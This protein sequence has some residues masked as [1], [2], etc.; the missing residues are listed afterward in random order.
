MKLLIILPLEPWFKGGVENVVKEYSR[1]LRKNHE[2]TLLCTG[3][4]MKKSMKKKIWMGIPVIIFKSYG[5]ILRISP[6]L[7]WYV[8]RIGKNF[9]LVVIHNYS[10]LLPAQVIWFKKEIPIPVVLTP[11]FHTQG[12][13][14]LLKVFRSIYDPF[15]K[16]IF[17]KR[18][19]AVQFVSRTEKAEFTRKFSVKVPYKVIYNGINVE[20]FT[21]IEKEQKEAEEKIILCAGRIEKYK[22]IQYMVRTLQ[23][24]PEEFKLVIIGTGSYEKKLKKLVLKLNMENRVK[25]LGSVGDQEYDKWL[26]KSGIYVQPSKIESFGLTTI[27]AVASGIRS[28][29][30]IQAYGLKEVQGLFPNEIIGL[31]MVKGKE[32][33]LV[34]TIKKYINERASNESIKKLDWTYQGKKL[35]DFYKKM[36]FLSE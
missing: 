21:K 26:R 4:S 7:V 35:E 24:L 6:K 25:F 20:R 28:I 2:L 18:I 8:R 30:N 22:N 15:F 3:A 12:S 13:T 10:T 23:Y 34:E 27:E 5:G 17:L 32:R 16:K 19:D 9:D 33:D 11:H 31:E 1:Y 29:V 36:Q 14:T